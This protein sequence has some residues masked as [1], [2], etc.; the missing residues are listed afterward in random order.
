MCIS[1]TLCLY[2]YH[3]CVMPL[4]VRRGQW[5]F[6]HWSSWWLGDTIWV[7]D[8]ESGLH[9]TPGALTIEPSLLRNDTSSW[10]WQYSRQMLPCPVH[11][12]IESANMTGTA[13]TTREPLWCTGMNMAWLV[14]PVQVLKRMA[15]LNLGLYMPV[16]W[17][18]NPLAFPSWVLRLKL[19]GTMLHGL[20][21]SCEQTM[22]MLFLYVA[23]FKV[24]VIHT[25]IGSFELCYWNWID[26]SW[27]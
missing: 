12:D 26:V 6:W 25:S 18:R 21:M 1:L 19:Y 7:L 5:N 27:C 16:C 24:I 20:L 14:L 4:V 23:G 9:R 10:Y 3:L 11:Q 15:D 8:I 2:V 17:L 13:A 22:L